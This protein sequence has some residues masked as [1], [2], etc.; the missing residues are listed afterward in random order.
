MRGSGNVPTNNHP[1]SANDA[2][3]LLLSDIYP[4]C[5]LQPGHISE[6]HLP[7]ESNPTNPGMT[8]I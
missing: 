2:Q 5:W 1:D 4:W 6:R 7:R 8:W 3:M